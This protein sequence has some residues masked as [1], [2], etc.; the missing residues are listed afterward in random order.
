LI[1]Q[2]LSVVDPLPPGMTKDL[3]AMFSNNRKEPTA[4]ELSQTLLSVIQL[5]STTYL[6][7]DGLDECELD[8][9]TQVLIHIKRLLQDSKS[10]VKIIISSRAKVDISR[11]LESFYPISLNSAKNCSDIKKYVCEVIDAK[12]E[13]EELRVNEPSLV[14]EIK[15]AL[16][17]GSDGMYVYQILETSTCIERQDFT[18]IYHLAYMVSWWIMVGLPPFC[19]PYQ[20][21]SV[22]IQGRI[23]TFN[24]GN[25][26]VIQSTHMG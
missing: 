17:G 26:R 8:D 19:R 18:W 21:S 4:K 7:I 23:L 11:S 5:A 20:A 12:M 6:V 13:E 24:T 10:K 2:I 15:M 16:I 9:R 1:K 25:L 14:E 22:V 3:E